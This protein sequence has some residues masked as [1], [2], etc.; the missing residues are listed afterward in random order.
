[1]SE[2]PNKLPILYITFSK[3]FPLSGV[4]VFICLKKK[5]VEYHT[6]FG[7]KFWP[8][9][10]AQWKSPHTCVIDL[11]SGIYSIAKLSNKVGEEGAIGPHDC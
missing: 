5:S 3:L 2:W 8:V 10:Q 6:S 1:M 4:H 9:T 7:H 11:E